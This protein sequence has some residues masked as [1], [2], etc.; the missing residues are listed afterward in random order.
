M[1]FLANNDLYLRTSFTGTEGYAD[2]RRWEMASRILDSSGN[3]FSLIEPIVGRDTAAA[4]LRFFRAQE[5]MSDIARY[6]DEEISHLTA[7]RKYQIAQQCLYAVSAKPKE[8]K[9]L[10]ERLGTEF[11]AWFNYVLERKAR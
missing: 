2:P 3:D 10:V 9:E 4:F 8:A 7:A 1:E 11:A 5:E 6:T